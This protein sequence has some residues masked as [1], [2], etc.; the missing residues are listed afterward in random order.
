MSHSSEGGGR[1]S[2]G[3]QDAFYRVHSRQ[4]Q[5]GHVAVDGLHGQVGLGQVV[6]EVAPLHLLSAGQ[7]LRLGGHSLV[8]VALG[9][10][11]GTSE[12]QIS[13]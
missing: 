12:R 7:L 3:D 11:H 9:C 1:T 6:G 4:E 5:L 13:P 8:D 2:W 10:G